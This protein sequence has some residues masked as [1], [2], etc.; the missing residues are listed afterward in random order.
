MSPTYSVADL[1]AAEL[2]GYARGRIDGYLD[3]F[4]DAKHGA[5]VEEAA[6]NQVFAELV[7][8]TFRG[9]VPFHELAARRAG[10]DSPSA[11]RA[12]EVHAELA[13]AVT[14]AAGW[15]F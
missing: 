8:R 2:N 5:A 9:G 12:R 10:H 14:A 15:D 13:A 4:T 1:R 7:N 6:A 3:G 11:A